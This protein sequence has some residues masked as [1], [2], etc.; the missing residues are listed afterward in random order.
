[1]KIIVPIDLLILPARVNETSPAA[2]A[3]RRISR[4]GCRHVVRQAA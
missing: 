4:I 1:M 2:A 3:R